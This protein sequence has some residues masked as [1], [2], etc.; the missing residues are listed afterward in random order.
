LDH[1]LNLVSLCRGFWKGK[2]V[3]CHDDA[4]AG[5]ITKADLACIVSAREGMLQDELEAELWRLYRLP[6]GAA[7]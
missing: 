2:W 5:R 4:E 7:G 6:K 3:S 1:P